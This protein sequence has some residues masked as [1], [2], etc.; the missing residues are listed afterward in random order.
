MRL[1]SGVRIMLWFQ[2][3]AVRT[4]TLASSVVLLACLIGLGSNAYFSMGKSVH[5]FDRLAEVIIPQQQV[6]SD[7]S[8]ALLGTHVK[9]FRFV[10]WSSNGVDDRL[11]KPLIS[12]ILVDLNAMTKAIQG[13]EFG[14]IEQFGVSNLLAKWERYYKAAKNTLEIGGADAALATMTLGETDDKYKDF[15]A[16]LMDLSSRVSANA[17]SS[18]LELTRVTEIDRQVLAI[19]GSLGV[20]FSILVSFLISRSITRPIQA[21]T[22]AMAELSSGKTDVTIGYSNRQDEIGQMVKAIG[23]FRQTTIEMRAMERQNKEAEDR[24]AGERK[25]EMHQ[26]A[27]SFEAAIRGVVVAVSMSAAQL[28]AASTSLM[29]TANGTQKLSAEVAGASE[30]ASENVEAVATAAEELLASLQE[31]N[32]QVNESTNIATEGVQQAT[33]TDER[34]LELSNAAMRIGDVIKLISAIAGQTNLLA[35]NATIEAARAGEAGKGFAVVAAEVKSLANKTAH[36]TDEIAAQIASIQAAT[37]DSVP[38]IKEVGAVI[39]RMA[40]I[41]SIILT[42]VESQRAASEEI[43]H[44]AQKA[45]AGTRQAASKVG[46]VNRGATHTGVAATQVLA[47]ARLLLEK[48]GQLGA[49]VDKF[50]QIVRAA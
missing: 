30:D 38:A 1:H 6:V 27:E 33:L 37:R 8:A 5:G 50:L 13:S 19:G 45:A 48:G 12:E 18:A 43:A 24:R 10:S 9:I 26:L 44:R 4:K 41:A 22:H 29:D 14:G 49:E 36:A 46:E 39:N 21:V 32:R 11:L 42:A 16:E 7:L 3:L 17:K 34:I 35:L 40:Q 47:S 25:A 2:D 23:V 28:E 31:I 20:L 15:S